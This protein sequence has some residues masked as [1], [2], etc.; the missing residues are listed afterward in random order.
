VLVEVAMNNTKETAV[1]V[2]PSL[3]I[4]DKWYVV[5][6][7]RKFV[8]EVEVMHV[9]ASTVELKIDDVDLSAFGLILPAQPVRYVINDVRWIEAL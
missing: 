8:Q 1:K 6:A 3:A 4:G 9:T 5:L 7:G 2:N